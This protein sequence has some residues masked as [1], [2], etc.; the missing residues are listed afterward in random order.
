[1]KYAPHRA[2][3]K[4]DAILYEIADLLMNTF[5]SRRVAEYKRHN[6]PHVDIKTIAC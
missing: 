3:G 2:R 1:V 5:A 6:I 4:S